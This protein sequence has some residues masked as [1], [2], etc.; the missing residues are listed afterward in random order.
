MNN[1]D[2][3]KEYHITIICT[4]TLNNLTDKDLLS[5]AEVKEQLLEKLQDSLPY[6]LK[7]NEIQ[8]EGLTQ[9]DIEDHLEFID[10]MNS[11]TNAEVFNK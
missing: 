5:T 1:K 4:D 10:N 9:Q 2:Q 11:E 6:G 3:I 8:I 7:I